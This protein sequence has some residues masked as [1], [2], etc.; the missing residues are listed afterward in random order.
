MDDEDDPPAPSPLAARLDR[1]HGVITRAQ[2]LDL[3]LTLNDVRRLLRSGRWERLAP[4]VYGITDH[5]STFV[6][7]LW[8]AHLH[9]GPESVV[10]HESAGRLCGF[11]QAPADR[12]VLTVA[13]NRRSP[14]AGVV[15][16]YGK[17]LAPEHV[18]QWNG[19]PVTTPLRTIIDLAAT[20]HIAS[21][22]SLL[23]DVI[24]TE[25]RFSRA[26][27][28][29]FV[30]TLHRRGKR[31]MANLTRVLDDMGPGEGL[32]RSE[33]ERL[34]DE[35]VLRS[36]LPKPAHEHPLPGRGA[37]TGFVD[38][39][40]PDARLIVE[41]DGRRWHDRREQA[42]LDASRSLEA[43][44][45]G[46]ETIRLKWEHLAHDPG[47]TAGLLRKVHDQRLELVRGRAS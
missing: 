40:W 45:K 26:T 47:T 44:A 13:S 24:V 2:C 18:E 34:L 46:F 6:R 7:K 16:R 30:A 19:L 28:G 20:L 32:P 33:L 11:R 23:Q 39:C 15:H 41:G 42:L 37:V 31:G 35:V 36:G 8:T 1:Q 12:V 22:R 21:L 29:A 5:R 14:E 10:S 43:S 3:G 27:V 17:D 38:R 25:H 9:A 4:S